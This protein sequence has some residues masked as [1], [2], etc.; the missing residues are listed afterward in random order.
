[1]TTCHV[2]RRVSSASLSARRTRPTCSVTPPDGAPVRL[3]P[4]VGRLPQKREGVRRVPSGRALGRD[5]LED[6]DV[7]LGELPGALGERR[8][9]PRA[10]KQRLATGSDG[11]PRRVE[12]HVLDVGDTAFPRVRDL[13]LRLAFRQHRERLENRC[14]RNPSTEGSNPSPSAEQAVVAAFRLLESE[15]EHEGIVDVSEV[16]VAEMIDVVA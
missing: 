14:G 15:H 1:M 4:S 3:S 13:A 16:L 8:A 6:D 7:A 12:A 5:A 11:D 2:E 10:S 9:V